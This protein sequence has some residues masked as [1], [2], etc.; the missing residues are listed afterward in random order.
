MHVRHE[1]SKTSTATRRWLIAAGV[2]LAT[3]MVAAAMLVPA[4]PA[5]PDPPTVED[6]GGGVAE[7]SWIDVADE[8]GYEVQRQKQK[9]SGAWFQTR[10]VATVAADVTSIQ[11][12]ANTSTYRYRVRAFNQD[13]DSDWSGWTE[14]TL[15]DDGGGGD[16]PAGDLWIAWYTYPPEFTPIA[17]VVENMGPAFNCVIN[18]GGAHRTSSICWTT[19]PAGTSAS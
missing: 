2:T 17:P 19:K 10:L 13:G 9:P 14:I 15:T 16:P 3:T 11:D 6:L 12:D 7:V 5:T 1:V 4:A 8:D 18:G